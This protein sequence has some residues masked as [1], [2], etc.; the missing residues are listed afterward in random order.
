MNLPNYLYPYDLQVTPTHPQKILLIGSCLARLYAERFAALNPDLHIDHILFNGVSDLPDRPPLDISEY[1]VQYIQIPIRSILGD[2]VVRATNFL[3][4]EFTNGIFGNATGAIDVML[5][6]AL[7]YCRQSG[8]LAFVSNFI[9]PQGHPAPSFSHNFSAVDLASIVDALNRH[10]AGAVAKFQNVFVMDVDSIANTLGKRHFM[11]DIIYMYTHGAPF[12][13]Y[14]SEQENWP[15]W[16]K[17]ER[18]RIDAVPPLYLTYPEKVDEFYSTVY[19]QIEASF[20]VARQIDQVK[21][22]IFDLDN[23]IWR[24]QIAEHYAPGT[25]HPDHAGWPLG[26]W[27]AI[28]H[29]RWRGILVAICS[30]NDFDV[31]ESRW[32]SAITLPWLKLSDFVSVKINWKTKAENIQEIMGEMNLTAKSVV[33]V[34]DSPI[35][36]ESVKAAFPNMRVIGSDPFQ[37]RRILLWAPE[38]QLLTL[39]TES[40]NREGMI[41]QQIVR[42]S[43]KR[44]MTREEFLAGLG[45]SV[46]IVKIESTSQLEFARFLE[47][48]NKTNQ[49]NTTGKRWTASE[50]IEFL[51]KDGEILAFF[52]QDKYAEYGLVGAA[53][54]QG[55]NIVQFIMSC[56]V[57][58]MDIETAVINYVVRWMRASSSSPQTISGRIITTDSNGPCRLLYSKAGFVVDANDAEIFF[59]G[60]ESVPIEVSHVS[61]TSTFQRE[62]HAFARFKGVTDRIDRQ[63]ISGWAVN[64]VSPD[65]PTAITLYVDDIK[66]ATVTCDRIRT[67]AVTAGYPGARQFSLDPTPYLKE[68]E[69]ALRVCYESTTEVIRNGR[70]VV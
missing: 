41:K 11:D 14:W 58:G 19:R 24:G 17:P 69:N 9:V 61:V 16:T 15:G 6:A 53:L 35:E 22:V 5:D 10:L 60:T 7:K 31:V 48:V 55:S 13:P 44:A 51:N 47:L 54:F 42:E 30:K 26:I 45:C 57:L 50:I 18:G 43:E 12:N 8:G 68:G 23:T 3:D 63:L 64:T 21:L 49:F 38:T 29:L 67:D 62:S 59:M 40:Q 37:T 25:T 39:T 28:H 66:V 4:P 52:V 70:R 20:R 36:R 2:G 32:S 33:F 65:S 1:D 27:E 46:H 34:D 56:R